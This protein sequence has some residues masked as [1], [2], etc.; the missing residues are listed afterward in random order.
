MNETNLLIDSLLIV[1]ATGGGG[2][3]GGD[4]E[5]MLDN[6]CTS[7]LNDFPNVWNVAKVSE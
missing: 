4:S 2:G 6:L 7:I 3:G 5:A 1:S